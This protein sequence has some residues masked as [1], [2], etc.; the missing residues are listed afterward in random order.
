MEPNAETKVR[1][2]WYKPGTREVDPS[3]SEGLMPCP[4]DAVILVRGP[5]PPHEHPSLFTK[6]QR[7]KKELGEWRKA[8]LPRAPRDVRAARTAVCNACSYWN[9]KGNWGL[10]ACEYPGCGCTAAKRYLATSK[11]PAKKWAQ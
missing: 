10:G 6:A 1:V 11:C 7:L 5:T 9:P 3:R 8:G 2:I 4:K